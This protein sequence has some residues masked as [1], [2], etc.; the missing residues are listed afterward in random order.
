MHAYFQAFFNFYHLYSYVLTCCVKDYRS[1]YS[2]V[3]F[4]CVTL[5]FNLLILLSIRSYPI[6]YCTVHNRRDILLCIHTNRICYQNKT[7]YSPDHYAVPVYSTVSS[8]LNKP[9]Q[10]KRDTSSMQSQRNL[11]GLSVPPSSFCPW[12]ACWVPTQRP[13]WGSSL[14]FIRTIVCLYSLLYA[15][16]GWLLVHF[17]P[18]R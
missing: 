8:R 1:F 10:F 2:S 15:T 7:C 6:D 9:M 14:Y 13:S 18:R 11:R 3:N 17:L 16:R 4:L 12:T 5:A